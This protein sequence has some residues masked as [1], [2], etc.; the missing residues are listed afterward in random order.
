MTT[1]AFPSDLP[2]PQ[3][4]RWELVSNTQTFVSPL[5]G[6]VQT[7]EIPGAR[8]RFSAAFPP[9]THE[10]SAVMQAFL[11]K[12]RG[13]ANRFTVPYWPRLSPR[14]VGGGTPLIKGGSQ[15]GSSIDIDGCPI[16][17][18]G[19]L[20]AGDPVAFNGELRVVVSDVDSDGSGNATLV[21]DSP[22]RASPPDND[23]VTISAPVGTFILTSPS[24]GWDIG[25]LMF[26]E[27]EISAVEFFT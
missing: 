4:L 23:P 1:Y 17:T 21:L 10:Q 15:T 16:S 22:V 6:A 24:A 19:W 5:T 13:Q 25:L 20:K 9:L 27:F 26:G 8:W 7:L 18:T 14:G 12:L 3:R 11:L 2:T